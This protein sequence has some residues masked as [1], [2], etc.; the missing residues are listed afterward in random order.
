[1]AI[2]LGTLMICGNVNDAIYDGSGDLQNEEALR[3]DEA[4]AWG[5]LTR[6]FFRANSLVFFVGVI[7]YVVVGA[8]AANKGPSNSVMLVVNTGCDSPC[9]NKYTDQRLY[10]SAGGDELRLIAWAISCFFLGIVVLVD[11]FLF[12]FIAC[13]HRALIFPHPQEAKDL[14]LFMVVLAGPL[15][16]VASI[17][18]RKAA[19]GSFYD[20]TGSSLVNAGWCEGCGPFV[21]T[22]CALSSISFPGSASGFWDLWVRSKIAVLEGLVVW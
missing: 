15:A 18:D 10:Q 19:E 2:E 7:L 3:R 5:P 1:M 14:V 9:F 12:I 8:Y 17:L 6:L 13:G 16:I 11:I 4:T 22:P 21:Y 20:C